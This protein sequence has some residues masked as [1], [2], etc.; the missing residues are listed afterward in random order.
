MIF[1]PEG[2]PFR[3]HF[4][5]YKVYFAVYKCFCGKYFVYNVNHVRA[6]RCKG[7]GCSILR[8]THGMTCT[9]TWYSWQSMKTRCENPNASD[10]ERYGGRGIRICER[11]SS[12]DNFFAD[13]GE[14]PKNTTLDRIDV[15]GDYCPENC[16][17]SDHVEQQRN[18]RSNVLYTYKGE[19]KCVAEWAEH[20]NIS[21]VTLLSRL[22][23]G[24]TFDK[25]IET[26]VDTRKRNKLAKG[27]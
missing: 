9:P 17:W 15:N 12:F 23:K 11:W 2:K 25:A 27:N 6:G 22:Y 24:W 21:V 5:T 1:I 10:Y 18:K 20:A 4:P 14:R 16:K 7:C 3:M 26:P 13:M 8:G 19:T